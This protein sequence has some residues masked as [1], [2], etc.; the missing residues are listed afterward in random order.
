MMHRQLPLHYRLPKARCMLNHLIVWCLQRRRAR[1]QKC[2]GDRLPP[3]DSVLGNQKES[4][5]PQIW[6]PY[7]LPNLIIANHYMSLSIFWSKEKI[8]VL[9]RKDCLPLGYVEH[10]V[11]N[12]GHGTKNEP[13]PTLTKEC[14]DEV[15]V[16]LE[17][18]NLKKNIQASQKPEVK[19]KPKSYG[20]R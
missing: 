14:L 1:S 11:P 4:H 16:K 9:W 18:M 17:K 12:P 19:A 3:W 20:Q 2:A 8:L 13:V 6:R 15:V 5:K 10:K 7:F